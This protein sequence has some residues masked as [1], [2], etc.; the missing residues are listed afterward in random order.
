MR[1][2][3]AS[4]LQAA[5]ID[6]CTALGHSSPEVTRKSYLDPRIVVTAKT[7]DVLFDPN[8]PEALPPAAAPQ[9][10]GPQR[11]FGKGLVGETFFSGST[12]AASPAESS[13][14]V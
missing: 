3:V 8:D 5:G 14:Q 12:P 2:S 11:L 10:I 7:C 13:P 9:R 1:R 6:A 4:H